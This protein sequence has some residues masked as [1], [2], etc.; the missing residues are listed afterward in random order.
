M[1]EHCAEAVKLRANL[2]NQLASAAAASGADLEWSAQEL[3]VLDL[4]ASSIDRKCDLQKQYKLAAGEP[5]LRVKISAEMRLLEAAVARLLRQVDTE[6]P[7]PESFRTIKARRAANLR[8]AR[9]A[10]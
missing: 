2:D 9:D 6:A 7:Q 5:K 4:I 1:T 10:G 3:Q 8:W